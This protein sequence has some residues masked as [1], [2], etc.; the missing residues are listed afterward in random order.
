MKPKLLE[1]SYKEKMN[2][3][4]CQGNLTPAGE[5]TKEHNISD[6]TAA[7]MQFALENEY[8]HKIGIVICVLL[9][10]LTADELQRICSNLHPHE[11]MHESFF[12]S[13]SLNTLEGYHSDFALAYGIF[14]KGMR[15]LANND[16]FGYKFC[17]MSMGMT[18][19]RFSEIWEKCLKLANK[20]NIKL[21]ANLPSHSN[22]EI[23]ILILL[24]NM[25]KLSMLHEGSA[26]FF[27]KNHLIKSNLN[28]SYNLKKVETL[29]PLTKTEYVIVHYQNNDIGIGLTKILVEDLVRL[30]KS[31]HTAFKLTSKTQIMGTGSIQKNSV[32]FANGKYI[33]KNTNNF[34]HELTFD[35]KAI[36]K[37]NRNEA[38]AAMLII[39]PLIKYI[40]SRLGSATIIVQFNIIEVRFKNGNFLN[41]VASFKSFRR[42]KEAIKEEEA[43]IIEN[44]MPKLNN[45]IKIIQLTDIKE[46]NGIAV[47]MLEVSGFKSIIQIEKFEL[48]VKS[49]VMEFSKNLIT[50]INRIFYN[51]D[52]HRITFFN[53]STTFSL[54]YQ[55]NKYHLVD[56]LSILLDFRNTIL[57]L[58]N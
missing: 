26:D 40:N 1:I 21:T 55:K 20:F 42:L 7:I 8:Y 27:L 48:A 23:R 52:I 29:V 12:D 34:D 49:K 50:D 43:L 47:N 33:T 25:D 5:L 57:K 14:K 13:H 32:F 54:P 38:H 16:N 31:G 19:N 58:T 17:A 51:S 41:L 46:I 39:N 45:L 11:V 24:G 35:Q 9:D 37:E 30:A 3:Q 18:T 44:T 53:N 4:N 28:N 2:L 22:S 6:S 36:L 56:D 15:L 10:Q